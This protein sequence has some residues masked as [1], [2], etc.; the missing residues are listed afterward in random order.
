MLKGGAKVAWFARRPQIAWIQ[1]MKAGGISLINL[2]SIPLIRA[3]RGSN[4][5]A[6]SRFAFLPG[7]TPDAIR[8]SPFPSSLQ[9]IRP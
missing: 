9:T 2:P 7:F 5:E 4:H 6:A 3:I 8:L 1:R